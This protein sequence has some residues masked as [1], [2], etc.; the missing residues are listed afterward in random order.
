MGFFGEG[1][2]WPT[3]GGFVDEG[4]RWGVREAPPAAASFAPGGAS[5]GLGWGGGRA[6]P[7]P[8]P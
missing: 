3:L 6:P 7:A 8:P 4:L 2:R 5:E 1:L